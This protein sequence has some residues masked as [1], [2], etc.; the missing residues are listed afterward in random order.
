MRTPEMT[1]RLATSA[2][3]HHVARLNAE[4]QQVH[5]EAL[6]HVFKPASAQTF[7]S[8]V[9]EAMLA[10]PHCS[11]HLAEASGEVIGYLYLQVLERPETWA[12]Y[13]QRVLYVHQLSVARTHR[14]RGYGQRLLEYAAALAN[15]QSITRIELDTWWFN[16]TARAFFTHHGFEEYNVRMVKEFA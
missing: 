6:P 13:A 9:F 7:T 5:A 12:R 16:G 1:I 4:V 3:H 11:L 14:H 2:D 15:Q 8:A 10:Q